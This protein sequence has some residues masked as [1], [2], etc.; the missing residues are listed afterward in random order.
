M[1]RV[2]LERATVDDDAALRRLLAGNPMDG[3]I[4]V[5]FEREPSYF[6]AV[7]VQGPFCQVILA[8]D[9]DTGEPVAVGARAIKPVFVN[10]RPRDVGY[11][12]DLRV[13][14]A[15][16]GRTVLARGYRLIRDL[17]ADGR[18]DL[19]Y[20]VI[21]AENA[22]ALAAL[23]RGR[24][25][26]PA[27]R[28]LGGFVSPAIVL[29]RRKPALH[30]GVE[31]VPGTDA[32]LDDIVGC[33]NEHGRA[34]QFAPVYRRED[35]G[36]GGRFPGFRVEDFT[37]ALR[38]GRVVGALGRWDQRAFK[39]TRVVGYRGPLRLL[40]PFVNAGAPVLGWPRFPRPG[41]A[42]ASFHAAFLAVEGNDV[43]VFGALL[44]HV[45]NA[46]A[47]GSHAYM[48]V[49]LHERDPLT[50]ALDGYRCA[51]YRGR[52]FCVHFDDGAAAYGVLDGRVPHVEVATL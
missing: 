9:L 37:L 6:G 18:T 5:A 36:D 16:R 11:L 40:R 1:A 28:D 26:L 4:R 49:G 10:G 14:P 33:L 29:G 52:L 48:V 23:T 42:L 45:Y 35:F 39:Q 19:Y 31:I 51:P 15:Y 27:Y 17:H 47:G 25:G 13:L 22:A 2:V 21:A 50:A 34:K 8:R 32:R 7:R 38:G 30:G 24:A 41:E 12:S 44:R 46:A 43:G 20:T 3:P